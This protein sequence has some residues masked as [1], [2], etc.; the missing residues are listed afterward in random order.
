MPAA[1]SKY[2]IGYGLLAKLEG[3]YGAGGA[4]SAATDGVLLDELIKFSPSQYANDGARPAPPGSAG[5][6][7]RVKPSGRFAEYPAK[8]AVK[9]SGA[10]YSASVV[11]NV[12][13]LLRA[14][15]L[16]GTVTTTGGSEKWEYTPT[17]VPGTFASAVMEIYARGQKY[18][19]TGVLGDFTLAIGGPDVAIL[20]CSF[21]ALQG[22]VT[23]V[24]L[25]A[26]TYPALAT[27]A[28]K[29][30]NLALQLG[31]VTMPPLRKI[32]L[33]YGRAVNPRLDLQAGGHGGF[34]PGRRTPTLELEYETVAL[35]T[36]DP[37][38]NFDNANAFT[39]NFT[40]GSVQY[41]KFTLS[42]PSAQQMSAPEE[43]ED[44]EVAITR[45]TLQLNPSAPNLNDEFTWKFD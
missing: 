2:V 32:T 9:G 4:C 6:Q 20:D 37:F 28:P 16:D 33:K 15:G 22:A 45:I 18:P 17:P 5:Y 27:D 44:G 42:G 40:V 31:G 8:V 38:V 29:A 43:D 34:G 41:N 19:M 39:W 1:P 23:D 12:H 11:P 30:V 13:A 21:K 26:I 7:R 35:A 10:A 25:P 14:C 24:S 36:S 3:S